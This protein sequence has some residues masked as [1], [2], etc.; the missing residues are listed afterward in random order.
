MRL[1]Q[2]FIARWTVNSIAVMNT[3]VNAITDLLWTL[4]SPQPLVS[5]DCVQIEIRSPYS[6]QTV[7][8][9]FVRVGPFSC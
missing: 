4:Q 1:D 3:E 9:P 8:D 7:Y 6:Q 5:G 2:R